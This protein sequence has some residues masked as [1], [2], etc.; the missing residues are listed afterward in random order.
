MIFVTNIIPTPNFSIRAV[1]DGVVYTLVFRWND[2]VKK[3]YMDAYDEVGSTLLIAGTKLVADY[4]LN[5]NSSHKPW[6]GYL[7]CRDTSGQG[8]DPDLDTFGDS[9]QLWYFPEAD[10]APVLPYGPLV[11][12]IFFAGVFGYTS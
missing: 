6:P 12:S 8:K 5:L 7:A 1:L 2:R 4:P 3:I 9:A 11:V 10:V